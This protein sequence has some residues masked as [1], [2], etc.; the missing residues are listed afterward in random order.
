[1]RLWCRHK[2]VIYECRQLYAMMLLLISWLSICVC[3]FAGCHLGVS[4]VQIISAPMHLYFPV[5]LLQPSWGEPTGQFDKLLIWTAGQERSCV[6]KT[7]LPTQVNLNISLSVLW[8]C[9]SFSPLGPTQASKLLIVRNQTQCWCWC[10][11]C[12]RGGDSRLRTP[13]EAWSHGGLS[14]CSGI[15][16][17]DNPR[18]SIWER[19]LLTFFLFVTAQNSSSLEKYLS[20]C[21]YQAISIN[22]CSDNQN[23][24]VIKAVMKSSWKS[25]A[26][27]WLECCNFNFCFHPQKFILNLI[28]DSKYLQICRL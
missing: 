22:H 27:T 5:P 16:D 14:H 15:C 26:R 17:L 9:P 12:C 2:H 20:I 10:C 28:S 7:V 18:G 24:S 4:L 25:T 13:R 3:C 11:C 23:T 21:F 19:H 1:M 8:H 6:P